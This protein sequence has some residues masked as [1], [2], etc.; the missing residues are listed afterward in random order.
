MP[1]SIIH[2]VQFSETD[3]AG[4]VHFS[5]YFRWMEEVEHAFFRSVGLSVQMKHG[6]REIGWPRVSVG[7]DY[8]GPA[9]FE[10]EVQLLMS[11]TRLGDRSLTYEVRFINSG[12]EIALGRA[13]TACC[14]LTADGMTAIPIPDDIRARLAD[15]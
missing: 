12:R 5:N 10:D 4:I 15:H 7:C 8:S 2:R 3:A 14:E 9:R 11:I 6:G 13:T 1:F